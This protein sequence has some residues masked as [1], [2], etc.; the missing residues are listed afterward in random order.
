MTY[1]NTLSMQVVMLY[2]LDN[3]PCTQSFGIHVAKTADFPAEVIAEAKR[4]AAELECVGGDDE[5]VEG[6]SAAEIAEKRESKCVVDFLL[7]FIIFIV[8]SIHPRSLQVARKRG[9]H[10]NQCCGRLQ[11]CQWSSWPE[12]TR[13][14]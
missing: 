1:A 10:K 4:K 9:E 13:P 11:S 6:A 8:F 7:C 3:G 5:E 14:P 12:T 2:H